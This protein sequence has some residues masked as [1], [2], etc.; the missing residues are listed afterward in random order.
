MVRVHTPL[1]DLRSQGGDGVV[2][3]GFENLGLNIHDIYFT[4]KSSSKPRDTMQ[5]LRP[6][7]VFLLINAG[8][9]S[10]KHSHLLCL[11]FFVPLY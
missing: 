10:L 7:Y 8:V 5:F 6:E 4:R 2:A 3:E 11:F 1:R 9:L